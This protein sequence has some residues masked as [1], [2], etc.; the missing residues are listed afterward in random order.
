M[1][2]FKHF[3]LTFALL[4]SVNIFAGDIDKLRESLSVLM[5]GTAPSSIDKTPIEGLYE[6][7]YGPTIFY[8]NKDASLMIRGDMVDIKTRDNLTEK[9]RSGARVKLIK[10]MGD[11]KVI[12]YAA[13]NEKH[14]VTSW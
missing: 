4:V 3:F 9:K 12:T 6:V 5:P 11:D 2:L 10:A 14:R 8:F 7:S 1:T 13:K